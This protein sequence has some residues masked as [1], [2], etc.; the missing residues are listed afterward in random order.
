MRKKTD[1][2]ICHI[3]TMS[4]L[5]SLHSIR[6]D[7]NECLR[8]RIKQCTV[9]CLRW[10]AAVVNYQNSAPREAAV[11]MCALCVISSEHS[12]K[13]YKNVRAKS[14]RFA[15]FSRFKKSSQKYLFIY[16]CRIIRLLI[17]FDSVC[18]GGKV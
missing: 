12:A 5:C 11:D 1:D 10:V 17:V 13:C 6:N 2:N 14:C 16:I 9:M 3:V 18:V 8:C 7:F 15:E 4:L